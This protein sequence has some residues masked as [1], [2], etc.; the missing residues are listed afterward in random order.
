MGKIAKNLS[1]RDMVKG[2]KEERT[3]E[4]VFLESEAKED[5]KKVTAGAPEPRENLKLA[6]LTPEIV[7]RLGK[8]LLDLKL[9]LYQKGIVEY[10]IRLRKEGSDII[11]S[12]AEKKKKN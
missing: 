5:R 9:E 6:Y 8:M 1:D 10:D 11:L 3:L 7:T 12:P 2:Y 4:S